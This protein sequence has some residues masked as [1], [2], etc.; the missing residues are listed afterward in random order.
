M[1]IFPVNYR[2]T[3]SLVRYCRFSSEHGLVYIRVLANSIGAQP[4]LSNAN[5]LPIGTT[6]VKEQ[7]SSP[8]CNQNSLIRWRVMRKE[9]PGFDALDG[10]FVDFTRA[11]AGNDQTR[12][13]LS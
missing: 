13:N 3:Y 6:V 12:A 7:F 2:S 9:A 1:P 8:D 11:F 10:D 5:P 4:Y